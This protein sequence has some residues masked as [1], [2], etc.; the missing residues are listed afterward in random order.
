MLKQS[1]RFW[2]L[3]KM[4]SIAVTQV[5]ISPL[6]Y[7]WL[8]HAVPLGTKIRLERRIFFYTYVKFVVSWTNIFQCIINGNFI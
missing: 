4:L 7:R 3:V 1:K 2:W 6:M 5:A 8:V